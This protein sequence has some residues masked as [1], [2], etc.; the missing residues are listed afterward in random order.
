[1]QFREIIQHQSSMALLDRLDVR[2]AV[3]R[4]EIHRLEGVVSLRDV[5][6]SYGSDSL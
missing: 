4:A 3:I 1:M 2:P 6:D 5:L